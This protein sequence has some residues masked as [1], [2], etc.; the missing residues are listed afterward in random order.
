MMQHMKGGSLRKG[1]GGRI[2]SSILFSTVASSGRS[3]R[4]QY[5][6][7]EVPLYLKK[8]KQTENQNTLLLHANCLLAAAG[9]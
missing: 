8:C 9:L 3:A 7:P 1:E 2:Q 5:V 4:L 6:S